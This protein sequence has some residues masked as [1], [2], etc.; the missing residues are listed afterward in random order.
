MNGHEHKYI[1]GTIGDECSFCGLLRTTIESL[2]KDH[3]P[4]SPVEEDW[5]G[6]LAVIH[7]NFESTIELFKREIKKTQEEEHTRILSALELLIAEEANLA[8]SEGQATSRLT[9]LW[10]KV[11][12]EFK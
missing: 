11:S 7:G 3:S 4:E 12:E 5:E 10:V 8:R 9:S 1:S 2:E 6:E